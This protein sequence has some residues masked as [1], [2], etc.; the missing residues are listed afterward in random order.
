[1]IAELKFDDIDK[2][3]LSR[4]ISELTA[5]SYSKNSDRNKLNDDIEDINDQMVL[6]GFKNIHG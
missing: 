2:A 4:K 3:D 1:M 5:N 6:L